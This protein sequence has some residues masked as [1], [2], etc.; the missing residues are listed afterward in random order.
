MAKESVI[1]VRDLVV[2]LKGIRILN[3]VNLDEIGRAHV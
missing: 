2:D 1:E 3:G